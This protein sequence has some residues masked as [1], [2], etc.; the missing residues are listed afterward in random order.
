MQNNQEFI[1]LSI[2]LAK[3]W[4]NR[5]SKLISSSDKAF[6]KKMNRMFLHPDGKALLIEL[7]DQSFRS[8]LKGKVANQIVFLLS[9]HSISDF[10]TT[11]EK[12]LLLFFKYFGQLLPFFSVPLFVK[13]IRDDTKNVVIKGEEGVFNSHLIKRKKENTIVNVNLIGEVV[14]GEIEA[15]ERIEKYLK[16]L[17][18]PNITYISIKISTIYSQIN[19]LDFENTVEEL[20][21][22]LSVIYSCAKKYTYITKNGVTSNKFINLDMEEYK[23]LAITV[24]VFKRTLQKD[25]FKDFYGGIVLQ[26][27]LPDSFVWME[28]LNSFA[29]DRVKNGGHPIKIRIVK[30]ANMEMEATEASQ[31]CWEMVTYTDKSDT[32]SNYKRMVQFALTKENAPFVHI[33]TA[34]HNLFELAY[35]TILSEKNNVREYHSIEMLEGMSESARYAI[36]ELSKDVITYAPTASKDQFI[37]AVAYLVRRLDEN[38]GEDNFI[39]HSFG[40]QVDSKDWEQQKKLFLKSFENE[41]SSFVGVK[42]SQ[43]RL[44][45]EW[46]NFQNSSYDTNTYKSEADTDFVLENNR[47][48]ANNI[49]SKYKANANSKHNIVPVVVENKELVDNRN[50]KIVLDKSQLSQNIISGKFANATSDDL[51]NAIKVAKDDTDGWRDL[52][53]KQRHKTLKQVANNVRKRR[54]NL[55]GIA[56]AEVGKVFT[57]SDVEV[58]EAVDFL[59]FYPYSVDY[60]EKYKNLEFKAKGVGVIVPPWNFPIA[61]ALGGIAATLASG[62]T[63]IIKPSSASVL[64]A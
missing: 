49:I 23:D 1:D 60:F 64:C 61:I 51:E 39:R 52:S 31:K 42:R 20:V 12:V 25:E 13:Q 24:E 9:K 35:A 44:E 5:A 11:L 15:D 37:N 58:S 22:R 59:E 14:L 38:T 21:K 33:G 32:D 47:I 55:I 3:K 34:S 30:G 54:D 17:Q 63:A 10:F 36:C 27:Y 4:Q 50:I 48:W 18:N 46:D 16:A 26:A 43:N 53:H 7:M 28:D 62:N 19:V 40:L 41:K 29:K 2:E 45:E 56:G 6:H 57:E 8:S